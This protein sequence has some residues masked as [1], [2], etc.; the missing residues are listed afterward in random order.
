MLPVTCAPL[1]GEITCGGHGKI[2]LYDRIV[3]T[4]VHVIKNEDTNMLEGFPSID[5]QDTYSCKASRKQIKCEC[6]GKCE[7]RPP[8]GDGMSFPS[9]AILRDSEKSR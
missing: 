7:Y 1:A 6:T 4:N 3:I 8:S 5:M 9:W 2:E